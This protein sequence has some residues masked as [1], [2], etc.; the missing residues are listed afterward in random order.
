MKFL[1]ETTFTLSRI[2]LCEE[3]LV[4]SECSVPLLFCL[5]VLFL[6]M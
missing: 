5:I 4:L 1:L 2:R 3:G 6:F